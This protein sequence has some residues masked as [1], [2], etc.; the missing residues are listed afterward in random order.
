LE[1]VILR[2]EEIRYTVQMGEIL[3]AVEQVFIEKA[4]G[5][6]QMPP[7]VYLYYK[8]YN[9]DLRVMPSHTEALDVSAVKVV[10]VHPQNRQFGLPTVMAT[11][12]L[13][14]PKTGF[15]LSIMDGTWITAM[16]TGAAS[17][18]ATKYLA[19]KDSRALG[20]VGAGAQA[21]TQLTAI[22]NVIRLERVKVWSLYESESLD[23]VQRWSEAYPGVNFSAEQDIQHVVQGS[24]IVV[25]VTPSRQPLVMDEWVEAGTHIN[26]VG[27]DAPGKQELDPMIL[28]RSRIFVDDME[29]ACHSGEV[30]MPLAERIISREDILGELG[31]VIAQRM[32]GRTSE[33]EV[34]VFTSTGLALEDAI[35]ARLVYQRAIRNGVGTK[36]ELIS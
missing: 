18:V 20:L 8:K 31:D 30:N 23:F 1:T 34:T 25:T 28:R 2:G 22:A 15:P 32:P 6:T 26:A 11:I 7:K 27:A 16:R 3:E 35:T 17:G 14:D 5:R 4:M 21:E 10:N 36:I 29:Q 13:I 19:R 33:D 9:G 12:I 24:D